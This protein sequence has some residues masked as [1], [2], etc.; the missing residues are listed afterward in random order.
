MPCRSDAAS[1]WTRHAATA[2]AWEERPGWPD[3]HC[4]VALKEQPPPEA[5][6]V[7]PVVR[8]TGPVRLAA[9]GAA[10]GV[11]SMAMHIYDDRSMVSVTPSTT[12]AMPV[13]REAIATTGN[14]TAQTPRRPPPSRE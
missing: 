1:G 9:V 6:D 11:A 7:P 4:S 3:A 12:K 13:T 10:R 14:A 8:I 2:F 5:P